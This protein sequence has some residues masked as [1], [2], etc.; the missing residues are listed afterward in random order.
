MGILG[1]VIGVEKSLFFLLIERVGGRALKA[2]G[3]IVQLGQFSLARQQTVSG[4][5]ISETHH[6]QARTARKHDFFEL[7][8]TRSHRA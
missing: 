3:R 7:I 4:R 6:F 8:L 1:E 2:H 5:Q